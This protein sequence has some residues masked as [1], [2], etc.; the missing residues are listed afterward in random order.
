MGTIEYA[1]R[2]S[3][4][5]DLSEFID[6]AAII[7]DDLDRDVEKSTYGRL[8]NAGRNWIMPRHL[9]TKRGESVDEITVNIPSDFR[10]LPVKCPSRPSAKLAFEMRVAK[11]LEERKID[12]L[13]SD[14]VMLRFENLLTPNLGWLG[15]IVNTHPA[16]TRA[17][18]PGKSLGK[19]PYQAAM[20]R[21]QTLV[22][23]DQQLWLQRPYLKMGASFHL[24][25]SGIDTGTV[26][27]EAENT[28]VAPCSTEMEVS[29]DNHL[30]SKTPV[31]RVGIMNY[32]SNFY[33][34]IVR[35]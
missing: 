28:F 29:Y 6:I 15:R 25:D 13:V 31:F 1:L 4:Y 14:H 35:S 21:A 18:H 12:V 19:E 8:P 34:S 2:E 22:V 20:E 7:T 16:I 3:L 9:V 33:P 32:I 17:D 24:I 30:H 23:K 10:H 11:F 26:L 27:A 5:G